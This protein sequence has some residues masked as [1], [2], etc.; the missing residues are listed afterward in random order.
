THRGEDVPQ[1]AALL[2][3]PVLR[4]GRVVL[5]RNALEHAIVDQLPQSIVEN[6]AR[7]PEPRLEVVEPAY[8]QERVADD[9]HAP[10]LAHDLEALGH[11]AVHVLEALA[12][13]IT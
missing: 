13:H 6:V 1:I 5:I 8:A 10:P 3:E 2:R 11:R 4:P 12:L 9:Q 7:N